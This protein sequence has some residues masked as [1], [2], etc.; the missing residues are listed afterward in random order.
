M[1]WHIP[2]SQT[3]TETL[4]SGDDVFVGGIIAVAK[5]TIGVPVVPRARLFRSEGKP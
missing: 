3:T 4:L 5:S 1:A 2:P